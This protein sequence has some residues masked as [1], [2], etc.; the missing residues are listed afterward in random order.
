MPKYKKV[1]GMSPI[2]REQQSIDF[3]EKKLKRSENY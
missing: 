2:G 1:F 3:L